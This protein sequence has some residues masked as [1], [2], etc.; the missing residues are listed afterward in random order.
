MLRDT[1]PVKQLQRT[2]AARDLERRRIGDVVGAASRREPLIYAYRLR[3]L[4]S[5]RREAAP[6]D[7]GLSDPVAAPII[8]RIKKRDGCEATPFSDTDLFR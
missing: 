5:S 7:R 2:S 6:T 4:E 8:T 3:K 1:S